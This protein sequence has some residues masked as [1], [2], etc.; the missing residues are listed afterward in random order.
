ML[1]GILIVFTRDFEPKDVFVT[2]ILTK[3]KAR[4]RTYKEWMSDKTPVKILVHPRAQDPMTVIA[5]AMVQF[6]MMGIPFSAP[7][8]EQATFE[9]SQ[10]ISGTIITHWSK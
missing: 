8:V 10:G 7:N 6:R 4:G 2:S 9:G 1:D 3:M 5:Q